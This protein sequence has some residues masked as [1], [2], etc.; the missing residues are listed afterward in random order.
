MRQRNWNTGRAC[1]VM[2]SCNA[3]S[4]P[5]ANRCIS[6]PSRAEGSVVSMRG[7]RVAGHRVLDLLVETKGKALHVSQVTAALFGRHGPADFIEVPQ[8]IGLALGTEGGD[9]GELLL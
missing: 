6:A 4:C 5:P 9:F 8:H 1:R 7:R 3:A 2:R